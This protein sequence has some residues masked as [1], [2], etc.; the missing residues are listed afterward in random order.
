M[1]YT[2]LK[3]LK[4][5]KVQLAVY[6]EICDS[7]FIFVTANKFEYLE[8]DCVPMHCA[9]YYIPVTMSVYARA[10]SLCL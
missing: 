2:F 10:V 5:L 1:A 4:G 3:E 7:S 6:C 9:I 8:I